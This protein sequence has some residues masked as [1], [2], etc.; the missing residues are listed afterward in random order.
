MDFF[1][2]LCSCFPSLFRCYHLFSISTC[3]PYVSVY[4]FTL[5]NHLDCFDLGLRCSLHPSPT[6]VLSSLGVTAS[7]LWLRCFLMIFTFKPD[8]DFCPL[9]SFPRYLSFVYWVES[10]GDGGQTV[11]RPPKW[12]I[13]PT[14]SLR[15][16]SPYGSFGLLLL[17]SS[18][19][20]VG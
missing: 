11:F 17:D 20:T 1:P 4:P 8:S 19:P 13:F 16:R 2:Y 15:T 18:R 9:D 12:K 14:F 3:R 5:L 7:S 10:W 6:G